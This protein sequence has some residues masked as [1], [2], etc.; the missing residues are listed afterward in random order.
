MSMKAFGKLHRFEARRS[1]DDVKTDL[2]LTCVD[3]DTVVCDIE[4]GDCLLTL[5]ELAEEHNCPPEEYDATTITTEE[6][7]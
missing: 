6:T 4:H 1:D 5:A 3:C 2:E 7:A